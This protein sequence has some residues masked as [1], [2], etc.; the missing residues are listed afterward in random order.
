MNTMDYAK[1][2][3]HE[4]ELALIAMKNDTILEEKNYDP[5]TNSEAFSRRQTFLL[6][7][8]RRRPGHRARQARCF[9]Y[10]GE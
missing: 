4:K 7:H 9:S 2:Q 6:R 8:S 3:L 1:A 5:E 10:M